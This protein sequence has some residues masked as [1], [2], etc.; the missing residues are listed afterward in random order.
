VLARSVSAP[1]E[2]DASF[3]LR[4][5]YTYSGHAVAC[6]AA[7]ANIDALQNEGLL[8]R[9]HHIGQR[10]EAA[11]S[12][13]AADGT[14]AGVRGCGAVW[15][16]ALRP[17]QDAMTIRDRMLELGAITRAINDANTFCPPLVITD[18][19]LDTLLDAFA[20][21]ASGK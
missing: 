1:L 13:L 12:A 14:I 16:A 10:I 7:H 19:E 6:A 11:L 20:T 8:G 9:V 3:I 15:A 17:D 21:A 18:D 5:G 2:S 4:H